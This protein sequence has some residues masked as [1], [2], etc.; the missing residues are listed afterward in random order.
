MSAAR[1]EQRPTGTSAG[2]RIDFDVEAIRREFP[3]LHQTING[4]PLV[5]FDNAA[6]SQRPRQ[7]IDAVSR[8]YERDH[9]NVHRG[10]YTLSQRAT[11]A[12]EG[13]RELVREFIN[14]A[15]TKEI[16]FV[17][18]TTE[19]VNLV[20]QSY[21]RPLLGPGDE[22]LISGLEHHANIVPWQIVCQQTGATLKVIPIDET[23]S[24]DFA[25]FERLIGPRTRLLALA[26]VSN[27]LGTVVP[28]EKFIAVAKA[29]GVP[30]L[31]DGAQAVPHSVVDVRALDC[32]FYCFS[33]HK[34][35]GPT[36]IG[37]LYGRKAL[38]Q[39]MPPWQGGGDMILSVT[40]E[41]T[42]YNDL[43][44]KFE[45]GTPD[46]AGVIGLGAAIRYLDGIGMERIAAYEHELLDYA[47]ERLSTVPGLRII[48]TSPQKASVVSFTLAGIHPHDIGT[49]LDTEGVAIRTGHHCAMPVMEF[50]KIPATARASLSFYNTFE[51]IDRL[52]AAVEHTR[53][54]L[55]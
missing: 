39:A 41:K 28:V 29:K 42:T 45:A 27:A 52:V 36:G 3:I 54:L 22:I 35:C 23:G 40:F 26:H 8:Y 50:F 51:E 17:R 33:A 53:R 9:A 18:G 24:V 1:P 6:S 44:W 43:P 4:K 15:E 10:V 48:G 49:V 25:A 12:Y 55:G 30:V 38:L 13:S 46:I 20:A 47:T 7:V 11:D 31:L 37:V 2:R 21:A 32:D 16:V 14:A 34:M 5:F 19:A